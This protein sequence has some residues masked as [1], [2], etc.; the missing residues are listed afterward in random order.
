MNAISTALRA[1]MVMAVVSVFA[2]APSGLAQGHEH[3]AQAGQAPEPAGKPEMPMM[4][5]MERMAKLKSALDQARSAAESEGARTA[6]ARIDEALQ[7]V[8]EDHQAM[9]QHMTRMMQKMQ[10]RMAKMQEMQN[11]IEGQARQAGAPEGLQAM[12]QDMQQMQTQIQDEAGEGRMQ[13]PMCGK[14]I[15]A[16][17]KVVNK[18]CPI[19]GTKIDPYNVPDRL[20]REFEGQKVGFCCG[21][22][23]KTWEGLSDQAKREKLVAVMKE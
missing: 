1:G 10:R 17:A 5:H 19:M 11:M 8:E 4:A 9:H 14:P 2:L 12:S 7:L 3:A 15:A 20:T 18:T 13:C 6:V 23:V 21:D 16:A 22:C